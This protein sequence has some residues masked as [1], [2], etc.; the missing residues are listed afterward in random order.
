MMGTIVIAATV[1]VGIFVFAFVPDDS[2]A[3]KLAYTVLIT[4]I[5]GVIAVFCCY[6]RW[7]AVRRMFA[8]AYSCSWGNIIR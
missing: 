8:V 7:C 5:I 6:R 3:R 4:W 1:V 2:V